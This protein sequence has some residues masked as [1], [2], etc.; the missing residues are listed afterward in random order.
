MNRIMTH[1]QKRRS[2][3]T[4]GKKLTIQTI[5]NVSNPTSIHGIY[6]YRGKISSI[7]VI[8][9]ISQMA[10]GKKLLDPFCGTGTIVY[11][12][13]KKGLDV[14]GVDPN[15]LARIITN[16]KMNLRFVNSKSIYVEVE[17]LIKKTQTTNKKNKCPANIRW[18]F[19]K[20]T[21]HQ[22]MQ[23]ASLY[24][25]MSD[26]IKAVFCGTICL[27]AR[28]CNHYK[29]TSTA[30]GKNITP[31]RYI[32]FYEKFRTKSKK[33]YLPLKD[34]H[35][36]EIHQKDSRMLSSFIKPKSIDYVFTSP[37]YFDALDY[38]AYY[39]R[40][41]FPIL[42]IDRDSVRKQLV[43]SI[44]TYEEDMKLCLSEIEQVTKDDAMIIFVVGD[45]KIKNNIINGGDFFSKMFSHR[46]TK[47]IERSYKGSA[48][49]VFDILN[50][51]NRKEQ[52]VIWDKSEWR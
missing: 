34:D 44:K 15:P 36:A 2:T 11:E 28:G 46:P 31:K 18:A 26:Y 49:K 39:A 1:T 13:Y 25:E 27:A 29:W 35:S 40:F 41:V 6:P 33:H 5:Q 48:S 51:T 7:D 14:V 47:I 16:G 30:V 50:K 17:K 24:D 42:G 4:P 9:V 23:M 45:K 52:I 19:H 38:T 3:R 10:S 20:K 22:I 21:M 32:D 8:N 37:P 12:A 43:Q